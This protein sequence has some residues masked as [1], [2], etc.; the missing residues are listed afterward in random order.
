[1]DAIGFSWRALRDGFE[2]FFFRP[3]D[4]RPAA[5]MR[6]GYACLLL[7]Q[8]LAE[9]PNLLIWFGDH[10][11]LTRAGARAITN[12]YALTLFS[13]LPAGDSWVV[14]MFMVYTAALLLLLVGFRSRW[15]MPIV[16]VLLVSFD[17]RN[18]LILDG[19]DGLLRVL[20]FLMLFMPIGAAFSVDA[21][22]ARLRGRREPITRMEAWPIRLVQIQMSLFF[23]GAALW[24]FKGGDWL[25]GSTV[26]FVSRL[27]GFFG[28]FPIPRALFEW[29]PLLRLYTWSTLIL[30]IAAPFLIWVRELRRP[31]LCLLLVF[32]LSLDLSMNL[33]VFHW[34]MLLGWS[35]FL[36]VDDWRWLR[37]R[38]RAGIARLGV[39]PVA[40]Y[41]P[42]TPE[43]QRLG[44]ALR[45][46][47]FLGLLEAGD[48]RARL[49]GPKK[50]AD[51]DQPVRVAVRGRGMVAGSRAWVTILARLPF[52][53]GAVALIPFRV[54]R[55]AWERWLV[56]RN[57]APGTS[58]GGE[59]RHTPDRQRP[60]SGR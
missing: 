17:H 26:Y 4:C 27:D 7:I 15:V 30:E 36:T 50:A 18:R 29:V 5:L 14:G 42:A 32:H 46:I 54:T 47:D 12:P 45:A 10:G 56:P 35:S 13:V 34:V 8:N 1:M 41:L 37:A 2:R 23:V 6:I 60:H 39:R 52:L 21:F 16:Y 57:G 53:W 55:G 51:P 20:G 40:L 48:P 38:A 3:I 25:N 44:E 9:A 19:E 22:L 59:S 31:V 58:P 11:V 24:K 43:W 28:R 33:L 49:P